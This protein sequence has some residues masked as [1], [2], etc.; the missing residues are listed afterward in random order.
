MCETTDGLTTSVKTSMTEDG[1]P[2]LH[3]EELYQKDPV[4][5]LL[6]HSKFRGRLTITMNVL[7]A[8]IVFFGGAVLNGGLFNKT[9]GEGEDKFGNKID[10]STALTYDVLTS[11]RK[12]L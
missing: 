6:F 10:H 8:G 9:Y 5:K 11:T 7:L 12:I 3:S 1:I 4:F 2:T